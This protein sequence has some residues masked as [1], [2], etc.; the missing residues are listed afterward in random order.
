[1]NLIET[2]LQFMYHFAESDS[3]GEGIDRYWKS[4]LP[5]T[6]VIIENEFFLTLH[7]HYINE[8]VK[9]EAA[10]MAQ[11]LAPSDVSDLADA[12]LVLHCLVRGMWLGIAYDPKFHAFVNGNVSGTIHMVRGIMRKPDPFLWRKSSYLWLPVSV[13]VD[14]QIFLALVEQYKQYRFAQRCWTELTRRHSPGNDV[15]KYTF[16]LLTD[17]DEFRQQRNE[18]IQWL[19]DESK[20]IAPDVGEDA[21]ADC[22]EKLLR[23]PL[24]MQIQKVGATRKAI[25]QRAMDIMGKGG[26]CKPV[27][28]DA[29]KTLVNS[30][31][32]ELS[33]VSAEEMI[34]SEFF[35]LLSANQPQIE[36]ILS[37]ESPEKQ[38]PKIGKR[39]F[40]VMQMLAHDP[41]LTSVDIAARLKA[42]EQ[43]IGRDREKI[44]ESRPL[45][46]EAIYS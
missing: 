5:E 9:R 41:D 38:R 26:E 30:M 6:Q 29:E 28:L 7:H 15:E 11:T 45:I 35:Q 13:G 2:S 43:T 33:N 14:R 21:M 10:Q 46:L 36:E 27:S 18:A 44:K 31:V 34:G 39:R 22:I 37:R 23:R 12:T 19:R 1:M 8:L 17:C 4:V 25:R 42:S 24:H 40:K 3:P 16:V 20:R 32:D